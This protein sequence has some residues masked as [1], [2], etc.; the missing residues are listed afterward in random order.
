MQF[1]AIAPSSQR[2][3]SNGQASYEKFYRALHL[4]CYPLLESTLRLSVTFLAHSLSFSSVKTYLAAVR[5]KNIDLGLS[6]DFEK[7]HLL[8]LLLRSVKRSKRELVCPQ[9]LH[10]MLPLL[11]SLKEGIH[12]AFYKDQDRIIRWAV[13]PPHFSVPYVLLNFAANPKFPL[14]HVRLFWYQ[15]FLTLMAFSSWK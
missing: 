2:T 15:M 5:Y 8:H 10:V 11:K 7:L 4:T 14:I 9:Y 13:S 12:I 3:Y 1:F 6:T